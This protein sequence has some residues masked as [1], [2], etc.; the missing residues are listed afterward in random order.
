MQLRNLNMASLKQGVFNIKLKMLI[1]HGVLFGIIL[2]FFSCAVS[3]KELF[4]PVKLA[5]IGILFLILEQLIC[6]LLLKKK[7]HINDDEFLQYKYCKTG[8]Q[9]DSCHIDALLNIMFKFTPDLITFK[10]PKLR[11]VMG[12]K[13][14]MD[15]F[16]F[17]SEQDFVGKTPFEIFAPSHAKLITM[18]D[19]LVLKDKEPKMYV[20]KFQIRG[21][22]V[23]YE[24][25]SAPIISNDEVV[26][27]MTLS[28][29][30]TETH[31]Q[32]ELLEFAN[33]QLYS[34]INNAPMLAYVLDTEGNFILGN[35]R[36][37]NFFLTG[38][39]ITIDGEKLQFDIDKIKSKIIEENAEVIR[40]GESLHFEKRIV[41]VNG[42]GYWYLNHKTPMRDKD[43]KIYAVTTFV[44]NIDAEKR[45]SEERETYIATLS[46]DLKTPAIAQV[47]ALELLLS[48]QLGE[49]NDE[50]KEMLNLTLDS[51]NYMYDMVY[52]LLSTYKFENGDITLNYSSFDLVTMISE[53]ANELSNLANENS[54]KIEFK[55]KHDICNI[56]ADRIELKRVIINLLSNAI[57]YAYSGSVVNVDI[58]LIG[59]EVEVKVKNAGP[60]I[61][62]DVMS[63]LFRK[64][65]T[66]SEK[67]NKVG[68]GLGLYLSKKIVE[69]HNGKI[70]AE[71]SAD[72]QN[73]FGFVIPV[74]CV[75]NNCALDKVEAL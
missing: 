49:L 66:H 5:V 40:T 14:F 57:N 18:Y 27:I 70:I 64:Y 28:R 65:V 51:C 24:L 7:L 43:G 46:H 53:S 44:R 48:G 19:N 1:I 22:D 37:R 45:I 71:S 12:S 47:R 63:K 3:H 32:T 36:A 6:N 13:V 38:V 68:I 11:Y 23:L 10:D 4:T 31:N 2:V 50:Q 69:A 25:I 21:V 74:E 75:K 72:N 29:D 60:Y 54:I 61:E 52:T 62:A 35:A 9:C 41:D 20:L 34:L 30:I 55:S 16:E 56:Y 59:D 8:N 58:N 33:N 26:G 42:D 73:M 17:S 67:Y 39:D 15:V